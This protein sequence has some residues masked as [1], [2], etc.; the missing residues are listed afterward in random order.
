MKL[1]PAMACAAAAI[2]PLLACS[3]ASGATYW[4]DGVLDA[5]PTYLSN[6]GPVTDQ[7]NN[8]GW[9]GVALDEGQTLTLTWSTALFDDGTGQI[10]VD[11]T[12][13]IFPD[14]PGSGFDVRLLLSD[15]SYTDTLTIDATAAVRTLDI[16]ARKYVSR[17]TFD[18]TDLYS[19]PLAIKGIEFTNLNPN[20]TT[21][22]PF[23]LLSVRST[24]PAEPVP[25]PSGSLLA[26][27]GGMLLLGRRR[28]TC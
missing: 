18:I 13:R 3:S 12:L 15:G 22:D 10:L 27:G 9:N 4:V 16:Q 21:N 26:L 1:T 2:L 17:Q 19:G 8:T 5:P 25:E 23:S 11:S 24:V 14:L 7:T 28:R 20:G 6:P